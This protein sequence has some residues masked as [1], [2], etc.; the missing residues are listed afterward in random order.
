MVDVNADQIIAFKVTDFLNTTF[1]SAVKD[2]SSKK[3]VILRHLL[4]S[5]SSQIIAQNLT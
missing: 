1:S 2:S 5:C 3:H 4:S